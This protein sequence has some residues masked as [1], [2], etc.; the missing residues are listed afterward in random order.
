MIKLVLRQWYYVYILEDNPLKNEMRSIHCLLYYKVFC[1]TED[2]FMIG[3]LDEDK[4][5]STH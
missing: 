4:T 5:N 2:R 1:K 3:L